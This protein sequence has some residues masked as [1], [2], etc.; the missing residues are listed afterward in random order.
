MTLWEVASPAPQHRQP[1]LEPFGQ[2]RGIEHA[3]PARRE[4][5]RERQSVEPLDDLGDRRCVRIGEREVGPDRRGTVN[6]QPHRFRR[7]E[8]SGI[9]TPFPCGKLQRRHLVLVLAREP[10]RDAARRQHRQPRSRVEEIADHRAAVHELLEVVEHEHHVEIREVPPEATREVEMGSLPHLEHPGD[11]RDHERGVGQW[12]QVHEEHAVGEPVELPRSDLEREPGLPGAT[13]AGEREQSRLTQEPL[14][15]V[16]RS[17]SADERGSARTQVGL[18]GSPRPQRREFGAQAI[19]HE[20]VQSLRMLEAFQV[21]QPEI[22]KRHAVGHVARDEDA[23]GFRYDDLT[24]VA[25]RRDPSGPVDVDPDVVVAARNALAGVQS[26]AD[27]DRVAVGPRVRGERSLRRHGG[28]QSARRRREGD[29]ERVALGADLDT[30]LLGDR[31]SQDLGVSVQ[32]AHELV[33]PE[34]LEQPGRPLDIGEQERHRAGGEVAH[35]PHI[36]PRRSSVVIGGGT[37]RQ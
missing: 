3:E 27:A 1:I 6:E 11:L 36:T 26:H 5:Q 20:I 14:D 31:G 13:R 17:C 23:G 4:L 24:A 28:A 33:A 35:P 25:C 15:V 2:R 8:L 19:D 7:D 16:H 10:Q 37:R 29:E 9:A 32:Q 22:P 21:V 30:P 12:A 18:L 34:V